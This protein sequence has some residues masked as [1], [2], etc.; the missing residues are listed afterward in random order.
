MKIVRLGKKNKEEQ[1]TIL[2]LVA[3]PWLQPTYIG[4]EKVE[5]FSPKE[6]KQKKF[7]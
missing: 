6:V 4:Q 2:F 7:D 5:D 3:A 1:W